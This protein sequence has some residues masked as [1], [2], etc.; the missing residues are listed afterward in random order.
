MFIDPARRC[1]V[2]NYDHSSSGH[3]GRRRISARD[4]PAHGSSL[5]LA[6]GKE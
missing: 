6:G 3:P 5:F 1:L 4:Q 2:G